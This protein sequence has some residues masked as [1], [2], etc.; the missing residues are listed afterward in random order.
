VTASIDG[1]ASRTA[2]VDGV[3]LHYWVGG[4]PDTAYVFATNAGAATTLPGG[5]TSVLTRTT[6]SSYRRPRGCRRRRSAR[7]TQPSPTACGR[8]RPISSLR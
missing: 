8:S 2:D 4:D 3:T 1:F 5:A 7:P 6:L